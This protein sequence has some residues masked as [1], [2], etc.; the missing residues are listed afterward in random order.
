MEA[1]HIVREQKN[2]SILT[3]SF[4]SFATVNQLSWLEN[5]YVLSIKFYKEN[6]L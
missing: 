5:N 1:Q 3:H 6:Y 2:T 4:D